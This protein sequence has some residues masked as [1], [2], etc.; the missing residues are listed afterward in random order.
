M[1]STL[2]RSGARIGSLRI[3]S[4]HPRRLWL[5]WYFHLHR[6]TRNRGHLQIPAAT[7]RS[8]ERRLI[9]WGREATLKSS[10]IWLRAWVPMSERTEGMAL[11]SAQSLETREELSVE[12]PI[13]RR[14]G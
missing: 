9:V 4:S 3:F 2:V 6:L 1:Q 7:C 12:R 10:C 13:D 11:E 14:C 5:I 8:S